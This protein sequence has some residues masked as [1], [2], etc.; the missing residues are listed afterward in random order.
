M[1]RRRRRLLAVQLAIGL[2]G[3]LLLSACA[4][5]TDPIVDAPTGVA[6]STPS[7]PT[8][9]PPPT[10]TEPPGPATGSDG[11]PLAPAEVPMAWVEVD[12][13]RTELAAASSCWDGL[14]VDGLPANLRDDVPRVDVA[15]GTVVTVVLSVV[16]D[17]VTVQAFD[18][19]V[20]V[21]G[22]VEP[23]DDGAAVDWE[24]AGPGPWRIAITGAKGDASWWVE[25]RSP[26]PAA[27][28]AGDEF[29]VAFPGPDWTRPD[30]TAADTRNGINLI[31][32][33]DHCDWERASLLH[34]PWPLD[35][36]VTDSSD[37]R[38]YVWDPDGQL[39]ELGITRDDLVDEVPDDATDTGFH[40]AH[41]QVWLGDDADEFAYLVADSG[42]VRRL[43][44][45]IVKPAG[46]LAC[47]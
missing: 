15:P 2:V 38:Q 35:T 32:G 46:I 27:T 14:C 24:V 20:V 13:E 1:T 28:D 7:A 43:E 44:R 40:T 31:A 22:P 17:E 6:S 45:P 19:D 47:Q 11:E 39:E 34:V 33:S 21:L 29:G 36:E 42:E 3:A 9:T 10:T 25:V 37:L 30:G 5:T 12:G 26:T 23:A 16:P 4:R 18:E 8:A 41:Q